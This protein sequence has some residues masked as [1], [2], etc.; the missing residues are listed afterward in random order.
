MPKG[1]EPSQEELMKRRKEWE[2]K[3]KESGKGLSAK[4][5]HRLGL[6]ALRHEVRH[7]VLKFIG[8]GLKTTEEIIN[9]IQ[10]DD[11]EVNYHLSI[12]EQALQIEKTDA[13]WRATPPGM[14]YLKNVEWV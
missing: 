10:L 7:N 11:Q 1:E 14:G 8:Y 2:R 9:E 3:L 13:G 6:R 5:G 12:L 4:E